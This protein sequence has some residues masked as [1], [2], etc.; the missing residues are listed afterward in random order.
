MSILQVDTT[1]RMTEIK[2]TAL[3]G[4]GIVSGGAKAVY[5]DLQ[6]QQALGLANND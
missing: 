2:P 5:G 4:Q 3:A 1:K 6:G